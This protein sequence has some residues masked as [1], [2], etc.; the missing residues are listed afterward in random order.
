VSQKQRS[1][2]VLKAAADIFLRGM[3][4]IRASLAQSPYQVGLTGWPPENRV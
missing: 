4:Q 1:E 3:I 2:I